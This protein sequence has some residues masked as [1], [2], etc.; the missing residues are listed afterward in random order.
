[1]MDIENMVI[2]PTVIETTSRGER[3]FDLFSRLLKDRIIFLGTQV[4]NLVANSIVAQLLYLQSEDAEKDISFYI[5]SPGGSVTDG[6]AIYDTMQFVKPPI[7]TYCL[8]QAASMGALLVAAGAPGKRYALENSRI[9][10]HQ[11]AGG[12][13]GQATDISIQAAE[14][15][16]MK[17]TL[18]A[19]MARHT[20]RTQD[21]ILND[22]DRDNYLSAAEAKEFGIVDEVVLSTPA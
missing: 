15:I 10:I 5:N 1:M 21:Q 12:A 2:N 6:L 22:T 19:I 17:S 7:A 13:G 8:G 20:G 16:R 3:Q 11:P 18:N 4:D 9:M 14:I